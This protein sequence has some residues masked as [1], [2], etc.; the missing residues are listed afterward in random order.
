MPSVPLFPSQP[1]FSLPGRAVPP[2]SKPAPELGTVFDPVRGWVETTEQQG[3]QGPTTVSTVL[4]AFQSPAD[5]L[6][7]AAQQS[8]LDTARQQRDLAERSF[9]ATQGAQQAEGIYRTGRDAE[10][11]RRYRELSSQLTTP[12]ATTPGAPPPPG[13]LGLQQAA[14]IMGG[15]DRPPSG[16]GPGGADSPA[17]SAA[18]A[19]AK[20]QVGEQSRASLTALRDAAAETGAFV[21]GGS[22]PA[23]RAAEASVINRG[24]GAL[25]DVARQQAIDTADRTARREEMTQQAQ[26]GLQ[27]TQYEAQ[28]AAQRQAA[29]IAADRESQ[30]ISGILS[31]LAGASKLY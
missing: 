9:N 14:T 4:P 3:P 24:Q 10:A 27:Q 28:L 7:L 6:S 13:V 18:Y 11:D 30:R 19:R 29:Q 22:N 1:G 17:I 26:F 20:D 12:P 2:R 25:G 15:P 8:G 21:S 16:G 31:A 23:L 5:Q